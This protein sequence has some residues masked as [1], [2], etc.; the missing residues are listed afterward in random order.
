M[1]FTIYHESST[2]RDGRKKRIAT[3]VRV[4]AYL[5][6]AL[7]LNWA[8]LTITE[9]IYLLTVATLVS[10]LLG[11]VVIYLIRKNRIMSAKIVLLLTAVIYYLIATIFASGYGINNGTAHFGFIPIALV[12]YF[13]LYDLKIYREV[14]TL[15]S[16]V[17]FY[18]FS[19]EADNGT[20]HFAWPGFGS[21]CQLDH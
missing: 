9:G 10:A 19:T 17:L 13:L 7:A 4:L 14:V 21:R 8:V 15:I 1:E 16:L 5:M 12:S 20:N 18:V 11:V 2:W 3:F 6:I